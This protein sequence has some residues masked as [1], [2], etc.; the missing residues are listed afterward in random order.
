[1]R[2]LK[3]SKKVAIV[4]PVL[5]LG[6]VGTTSQGKVPSKRPPAEEWGEELWLENCWHCHGKR[7]LGDG[8]LVEAGPVQAPAVAG[9]VPDDR[10]GWTQVIHRGQGTMPAFAPVFDR[11]AARAILTWLDALDPETGDGP[12]LAAKEAEEEDPESDDGK[13]AK[14]PAKPST[15]AKPETTEDEP[16]PEAAV[17]PS[18]E[19]AP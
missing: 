5:G 11:T 17:P 9:R 8:P 16:S 15:D 3:V 18:D 6:V 2:W 7:G 14:K 10:E 1:M 19:P 12:S 13:D 4:L